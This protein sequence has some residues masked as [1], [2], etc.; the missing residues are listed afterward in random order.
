M[1]HQAPQPHNGILGFFGNALGLVVGVLGA[2][3]AYHATHE[4]FVRY[5]LRYCDCPLHDV[6]KAVWIFCLF[7]LIFTATWLALATLVGAIHKTI[8]YIALKLKFRSNSGGW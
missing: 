5:I 6:V 1:S 4:Y 8:I 7:Y 3:P 2:M